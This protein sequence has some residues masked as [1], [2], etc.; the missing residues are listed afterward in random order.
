MQT[1]KQCVHYEACAD[2]KRL[3]APEDLNFPFEC[4][5]DTKLCDWYNP[6]ILPPAYIGLK[7]WVPIFYWTGDTK[8]YEGRVSGLQQKAD[9]SWKIRITY[10][11]MVAD[12]TADE[13]REK[14][15]LTEEEAVTY[16]ATKEAQK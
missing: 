13:F 5:S 1:C 8:I 10:N 6:Q 12:Y 9:K 15:F 11:H 2:W 3:W 7:V 14:I 4:E 16:V